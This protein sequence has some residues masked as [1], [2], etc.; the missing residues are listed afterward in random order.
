MAAVILPS[1]WTRQPQGPVE[2]DWNNS[3]TRGL[4]HALHFARQQ[5][6]VTR[7]R[8]TLSRTVEPTATPAGVGLKVSGGAT[9]NWTVPAAFSAGS[10]SIFALVQPAAWVAYATVFT[11]GY[12][13]PAILCDANG[14]PNY[15]GQ[16]GAAGAWSSSGTGVAA[17]SVGSFAMTRNTSIENSYDVYVN[18]RQCVNAGYGST[19]TDPTLKFGA[20]ASGGSAFNGT[21]L[22]ALLYSAG[23]PDER[24]AELHRNP[25]QLFRPQRRRLYIVT[26]TG[27][28][29]YN[30]DLAEAGTAADSLS[31]QVAF[32]PSLAESASAAD[33][34]SAALTQ[35]ATQTETASAA[36]TVATGAATYPVTITETA[37]AADSLTT[38][39]TFP[40][41][42]GTE[43]GAA[44]DTVSTGAA[45]YG[46][47]L[48][49]VASAI[50]A[51]SALLNAAV[52]LA[53]S[54]S[55]A[56]TVS[57]LA[58]LL[59]ALAESVTAGD[60]YS[61]ALNSTSYNVSLSEAASAVDSLSAAWQAAVSIAESGGATD[62]V[63]AQVAFAQALAEAA[64]ALDTVSALGILGVTIAEVG[65]ATDSVSAPTGF[66]EVPPERV[67]TIE[68]AD[69][70]ITIET[71]ARTV[72]LAK[73]RRPIRILN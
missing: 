73:T 65:N 62:S 19:A 24:V 36:D 61:S 10:F 64:M 49:E 20:E 2:V 14:L 28:S 5:D 31:A 7:G 18:G 59:T 56:D 21:Y 57:S 54:G 6:L 55:A 70:T 1:R 72:R 37:A 25:W 33:A 58:T 43:A 17:G 60:T 13:E 29:S 11:K 30:V 42:I 41:S 66:G 8:A 4:I 12:Y 53:E 39:A 68:F 45:I 35:A 40:R 15:G 32:A 67:I 69:R 63:A 3:L 44:T 38:T 23:L 34:I 51:V 22:L 16:G 9:I 46:V 71:P 26:G 27:G 47:D 52:T 48:A 50:D